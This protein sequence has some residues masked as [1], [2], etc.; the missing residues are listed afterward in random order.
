METWIYLPNGC[1]VKFEWDIV[2][3]AEMAKFD[4]NIALEYTNALLSSGASVTAP[5]LEA[6]EQKEQ[7]GYVVYRSKVNDDATETP[8]IDLYLNHEATKFKFLTVYL[9]TPEDIEAFRHASGIGIAELPYWEGG[10]LERGNPK[11]DKYFVAPRKPLT[12]VHKLNERYNPDEPEMAK[13]KPKR[14]FVRWDT[15]VI[16]TLPP[17]PPA[18][19]PSDH[20][21]GGINPYS[22]PPAMVTPATP[23]NAANGASKAVYDGKPAWFRTPVR[24]CF[25]AVKTYILKEIYE[26]NTFAMNGSL[27]KRGISVKGVFDAKGEWAAKPAGELIHMLAHR[28]D[29]E[30]P[31]ASGQ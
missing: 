13:R 12:V 9:N 4:Y 30:L 20:P 10:H 5:G 2:G 3:T 6:G 18:P 25:G 23:Q 16:P 31:Q 8:I 28:H 27:D 24:D 11:T 22:S 14:L 7:V 26:N 29:E 15:V 19:I 21:P 17:A 1:K